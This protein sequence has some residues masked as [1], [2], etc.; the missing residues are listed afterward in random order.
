MQ[1]LVNC[2][3]ILDILDIQNISG[4]NQD[5]EIAFVTTDEKKYKF[6]FS[7][8]WDMRYSM[9]IA[10]V[11]RFC[12]FREHLPTDLIENGIY[13]VEDSEYIKYF[14]SQVLNAYSTNELM[15][16]VII[17]WTDTILD[18]LVNGDKPT[19]VPLQ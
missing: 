2:E 7:G 3:F 6:V 1:R 10:N 13:V 18:L 15:H 11:E 5:F 4:A 14:G 17:D 19:L 16:Y 8:V 12:R 9:E